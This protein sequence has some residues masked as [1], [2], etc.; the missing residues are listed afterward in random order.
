MTVFQE[1]ILYNF[2][3]TTD[4]TFSI[5]E[6][7]SFIKK[8]DS[9]G[10]TKRLAEEIIA[11]I[12]GRS[13]AFHLENDIFISRR[14]CFESAQFVINPSRLEIMNGILIPGHRCI[15]FANPAVLPQNYSFLWQGRPISHTSTEGA[16]KEFYPYYTLFGEEYVSM[17]VASDN[18]ENEQSFNDN[19]YDDPSEVSIKTLDMSTIYRTSGFV[20]GDVLVVKTVD[21]QK[22]VFELERVAAGSWS[23][24]ELYAWAEEAEAAFLEVFA[25]RGACDSIEEQLSYAYRY[26]GERMREVP[27]Y[28]LDDFLYN[29]TEQ[30]EIVPYGIETR[31]WF[32]G[33]EIPDLEDLRANQGPPDRTPL[34]EILYNNGIP[35]SEYVVQSYVRNALFR[36]EDNIEQITDCVVPPS[37]G[38]DPHQRKYVVSYIEEVYEEFSKEY[39]HFADNSMGPIRKRICEIHTAVIDHAVRINKAGID[40]SWFPK[41]TFII[42]S[43]IQ[44]HAAGLLEDLDTDEAP[45]AAALEAMDSSSDNML[46]TYEEIKD[47]MEQSIESFRRYKLSVVRGSEAELASEEW[48]TFQVSLGGTDVWRRFTIPSSASLRDLHRAIQIL[49][50]WKNDSLYRFVLDEL[51]DLTET[52][53]QLG[54]QSVTLDTL[55]S[56]G[57]MEFLYEYGNFWTIRVMFLLNEGD[58]SGSENYCMAGAGASP[59]ETIEGPVQF[60]RYVN[61]S[62]RGLGH[63]RKHAINILGQDFDLHKFNMNDINRKLSGLYEKIRQDSETTRIINEG[64]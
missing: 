54:Y 53:N 8:M 52:I 27:A 19:Q 9:S 26:G 38:M 42:F 46:E 1:E 56:K 59:P 61:A 14:G 49:F 16:P 2:L 58:L 18:P 51:P 64:R 47:L 30:I 37:L 43:Q 4:D 32:A 28:A 11:L 57:K 12:T 60:R 22:A 45:D 15:P 17:Y 21:W 7:V 33:K 25:R 40:K 13:L 5:G 35:V 39:S 55:H 6:V 31:F 23:K 3:E 50:E 36:N 34:E 24:C 62:K 44:D 29:Q 63:D 41:H 48:L 20:P 10:R